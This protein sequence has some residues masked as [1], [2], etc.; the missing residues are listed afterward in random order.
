MPFPPGLGPGHL[1]GLGQ[2]RRQQL[3][4]GPP[5]QLGHHPAVA[6]V[7]VDLTAH[8][9][10]DDDRTVV[11]HGCRRLVARGLDAEDPVD[12]GRG[13]WIGGVAMA[14]TLSTGAEGPSYRRAVT[15]NP[16]DDDCSMAASRWP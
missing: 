13:P 2:H 4:V 8:H 7:Q 12:R 6:G 3:D 15:A 10:G 16:A 11:D 9:R 5:G 14:G 1:Q